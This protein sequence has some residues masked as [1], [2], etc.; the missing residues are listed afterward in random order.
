MKND[1]SE[2]AKRATENRSRKSNSALKER[3]N[4]YLYDEDF[5]Y[6]DSTTVISEKIINTIKL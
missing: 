5:L 4:S 6:F 2:I 3:N 1:S